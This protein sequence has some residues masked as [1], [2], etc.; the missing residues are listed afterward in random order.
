[1]IGLTQ[2]GA[3]PLKSSA[4]RV[5]ELSDGNFQS[6]LPM[7]GGAALKFYVAGYS[8]E[9]LIPAFCTSP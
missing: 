4:M 9:N 2:N 1:M 5:Q 8:A 6:Y 3:A 7:R